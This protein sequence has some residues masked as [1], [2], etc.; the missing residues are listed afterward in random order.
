MIL[1]HS[2]NW[3]PVHADVDI[4]VLDQITAIGML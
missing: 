2:F 3:V 4:N 1:R